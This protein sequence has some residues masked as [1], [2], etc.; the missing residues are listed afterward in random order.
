MKSLGFK[1]KL[2]PGKMQEYKARHDNLW[3]ELAALLK[4]SGISD[5]YI[6]LDEE[7]NTLFGT[8]QIDE[9]TALSKLPNNPVMQQWWKYMADIMESNADNSPVNVPLIEMFYLR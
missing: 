8:Y 7:T 4:E 9:S 6:Y 5:Y 3:P 2:F 1:M